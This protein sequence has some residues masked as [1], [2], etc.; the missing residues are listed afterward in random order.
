V[1]AGCGDGILEQKIA[2]NAMSLS[3]IGVTSVDFAAEVQNVIHINQTPSTGREIGMLGLPK[4]KHALMFAFGTHSVPW[5]AYLDKVKPWVLIVLS[6]NHATPNS[7]RNIDKEVLQDTFAFQLIYDQNV[8]ND[9]VTLS[10]WTRPEKKMKRKGIRKGHAHN[11]ASHNNSN[12]RM[13]VL[14]NYV[15]RIIGR[16]RSKLQEIECQSG[17]LVNVLRSN[18]TE[19][20]VGIEMYGSETSINTAQEMIINLIGQR[21][22]ESI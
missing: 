11:T 6:D 3:V 13:H 2:D 4:S 8:S 17:A 10:I 9:S 5:M 18:A 20:Q 21:N 7:R 1:S 12:I 19:A 16:R 22:C 15:G 14:Q